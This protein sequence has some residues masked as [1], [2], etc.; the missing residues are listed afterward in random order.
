MNNFFSSA[1]GF[2]QLLWCSVVWAPVAVVLT[3]L[4]VIFWVSV[5][6]L[7]L[8]AVV[9]AIE[10]LWRWTAFFVVAWVPLRFLTRWK[11]LHLDSKDIL[12]E[13]DNL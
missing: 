3:F 4:Y 8:L 10:S 12:N 11:R 7:P 9:C 13:R 1:R 5:F 6:L 2:W